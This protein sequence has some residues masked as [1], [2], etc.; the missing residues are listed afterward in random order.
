VSPASES[1]AQTAL[2]FRR[3][4]RLLLDPVWRLWWAEQA[5]LLLEPMWLW[6]AEQAS[7][8]LEPM[9]L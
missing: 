6:W 4:S 3:H 8:L 5:S 9:W 1:S 2:S 7:L